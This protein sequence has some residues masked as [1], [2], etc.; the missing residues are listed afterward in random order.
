MV[1]KCC[2]DNNI[3]KLITEYGLDVTLRG[4][5]PNFELSRILNQARL[6]I[7][8]SYYEGHPKALLE[9]MSCGL[10]CIGTDVTGIREDIDHLVTGYLCKT[11][12]ES[13]AEALDV[14]ISDEILQAKLGR[15]A[16]NYILENYSLDKIIQQ[17]L[18]VIKE[19][20]AI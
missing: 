3:L 12:F 9:A 10:P 4:T 2:Y 7:L 6:F 15:N 20:L 1:G 5:V 14:L 19:V 11:D 18:D 16:R 13:I 8:P 17:E